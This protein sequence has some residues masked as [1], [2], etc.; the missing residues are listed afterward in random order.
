MKTETKKAFSISAFSVSSV[1]R[2]PAP[3]S[4][5]HTFYLYFL[6]LLMYLKKFFLLFSTSLARFNS[7]LALAI[8]I[9]FMHTLTMSLHS[10]QVA[11]PRFHLLHISCLCLSFVST[12]FLKYAFQKNPVHFW[13][14]YDLLDEKWVPLGKCHKIF[15]LIP[16]QFCMSIISDLFLPLFHHRGTSEWKHFAF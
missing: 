1:F 2:V 15:F 10:I 14:L 13:I 5:R 6:L 9:A 11:C 7:K 3:F 16:G 4:S 12:Y 8:L